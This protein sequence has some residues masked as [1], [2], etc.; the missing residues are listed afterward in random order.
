MR[1]MT[2]VA[3]GFVAGIAAA[4]GPAAAH[5]RAARACSD[6]AVLSRIVERFRHQVT[7]V[8]N[9]PDVRIV[10]LLEVHEHRYLPFRE[11]RPIAR[12]YCGAT[13]L[14]SDG[15]RREMWYLIEDRMGFV[16]IGDGVEFCVSGFDRWNVYDGRCRVLR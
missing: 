15:R 6:G 1:R 12:R 4:A 10:D 5:D 16:G 9:L 11:D 14:L 13:A 8:P 2:L 3:L 7:H